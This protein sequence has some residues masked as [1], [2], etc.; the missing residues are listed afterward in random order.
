VEA[1]ECDSESFSIV[2]TLA[3]CGYW[4][5]RIHLK[6]WSNLR[7]V[8]FPILVRCFCWVHLFGAFCLSVEKF[9]FWKG[10]GSAVAEMQCIIE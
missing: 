2:I 10:N 8:T 9:A 7:L 4:V 6:R 5:H 1:V 3:I